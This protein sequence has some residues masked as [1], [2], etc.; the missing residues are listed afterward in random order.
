[1]DAAVKFEARLAQSS[2]EPLIIFIILAAS[3]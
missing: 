2:L 1:M 3:Q